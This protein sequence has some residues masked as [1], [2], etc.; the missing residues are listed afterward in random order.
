MKTAIY[1]GT[2]D[3]VTNGHVDVATR[4]ASLF[5]HLIVAVYD[6]PLKSLLFATEERLAMTR[7]ALKELPNVAVQ[8]Y[9][10]LT[11]NFARSVG[12][13][14]IVRGLRVLS[15]FELE[16]QMALTNRKL[17]PGIDTVCLITSQ[18]YAFLSSSVAKEIAMVGGCVDQMV[19][20]HVMKALKEK[21]HRL[22]SEAGKHVQIVSL[23]D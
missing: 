10:G 7:E 8:S 16:F 21:F 14:V 23:R 5:D 9:S 11:V 20:P 17:A 3:P 22:G 13:Q 6:R 4:A 1:P 2:F 19:P 15:D 18:E 12:A